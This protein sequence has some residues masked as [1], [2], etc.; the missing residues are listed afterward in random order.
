L[1][2][3]DKSNYLSYY[4]RALAYLGLS[5]R[6]A[7]IADLDAVLAIQPD[8]SAALVQRGKLYAWQGDFTKAVDDLKKARGQDEF[9]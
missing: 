5:S 4:K 8:F 6:Q 1:V 2:E 9:V 7:A 3:R